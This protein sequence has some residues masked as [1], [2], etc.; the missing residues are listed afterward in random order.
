[1]AGPTNHGLDRTAFGETSTAEN[2]PIVALSFPYSVND[3]FVTKHTNGQGAISQEDNMAILQSGA[4]AN[5]S[6]RVFSRVPVRY[7]PGQGTLV[8]FTALFPDVG[9]AGSEQFVGIGEVGDGFFVGYRGTEFG[10]LHRHSGKPE[11]RTV[12]ITADADTGAGDITVQLNAVS[13]A[14]A[15]VQG[16]TAREVAVKVAAFDWSTVGLGWTVSVID[17]TLTFRSWSEAPKAG[18]FSYVDTDT[19][20]V[21]ATVT[22]VVAGVT[23]TDSWHPQTAWSE[24]KLLEAGDALDMVLNPTK[25]NVYQIRYQW[26]GYGLIS[27]FIESQVTGEITLVHRV[28]YSNLRIIPSLQNPTLPLQM[29]V[30]NTTNTSNL[31]VKVGSMGGL[32]EGRR[33]NGGIPR[34]D[35][36]QRTD[37]GTT[38]VPIMTFSNR[39]VF[40]GTI[41]RVRAQLGILSPG[42]DHSKTVI[43]RV[44]K[45]ATLTGPVAFADVDTENSVLQVDKAATGIVAGARSVFSTLMGKSEGRDINLES[46]NAVIGPGETLTIT[47]ETTSIENADVTAAATVSEH[48]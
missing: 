11:I 7:Q 20:G 1:M 47:A 8:R 14:I 33:S 39:V 9:V 42:V 40:Q 34:A 30:L 45:N 3:E 12:E 22:Q 32:I 25:G 24:H 36:N 46:I 29:S 21:T 6:A 44:R 41:N 17:A 38:E 23:A 35:E 10:F 26:L 15:V 28:R 31:T 2:T 13:A 43:I 18:A 27:F 5:S 37:V 19:T 16:D 4:A 48:F